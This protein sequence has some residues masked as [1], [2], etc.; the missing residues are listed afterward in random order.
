MVPAW[1][2]WEGLG[3]GRA[4]TE[5]MKIFS[6]QLPEWGGGS[7][8]TD[9]WSPGLL[10]KTFFF[11]EA[12]SNGEEKDVHGGRQSDSVGN[13]PFMTLRGFSVDCFHNLKVIFL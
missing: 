7:H 6:T 4:V 8:T 5:H 12:K 13:K 3:P 1:G 10:L 2:L 9:D 11:R